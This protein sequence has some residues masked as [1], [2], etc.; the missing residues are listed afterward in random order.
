[1]NPI[2]SDLPARHTPAIDFAYLPG[3][4]SWYH[5]VFLGRNKKLD[6]RGLSPMA[7]DRDPERNGADLDE[8]FHEALELSRAERIALLDRIGAD[9]PEIR[10]ELESMLKIA[11]SAPE[12]MTPLDLGM[13]PA[14]LGRYEI[15][16][17]LGRGGMGIVFEARDTQLQRTVALKVLSRFLSA[18]ERGRERFIREARHLARLQHPNIAT[19]HSLEDC[20]G[21]DFLTMEYIDGSTLADILRERRLAVDEIVEL[22][23]QVATGLE[24]AHA[25]GICHCD[26]KPAN[27][28][29]TAS[30]RVSLLDFGIS[31][32]FGPD[33]L[34]GDLDLA[35]ATNPA[36]TVAGT[37]G[38]R[39]PEQAAGGSV[40]HRSDLWAFGIIVRECLTGR[41]WPDDAAAADWKA[42]LPDATSP[43]LV[44]IIRSCLEA[45]SEKRRITAAEIRDRLNRMA[46]R[47]GAGHRRAWRIG[48]AAILAT[49]AGLLWSSLKPPTGPIADLQ[50]VGG[51]TVRA[52]NGTDEI[53]WV[54]TFDEEVAGK[55]L[56]HSSRAAA[57]P[58]FQATFIALAP[59]AETGLISLLESR[60]GAERWRR[61]PEWL[62]PV[63]AIGPFVYRWL[64][65]CS[66]PGQAEP[67]LLAAVRDGIWYAMGIEAIS[68]DGDLLGVYHHPGPLS[69][70]PSIDENSSTVVMYGTNSSARFD[71]RLVPFETEHHP[72]CVVLL[73]AGR[74]DGQPFPYSRD[75]PEDRD[76][77]SLPPALERAYLLIPMLSP[78]SGARVDMFRWH[79]A[80]SESGGAHAA[81]EDGR[82]I[83]LDSDLRPLRALISLRTFADSLY[84]SGGVQNPPYL[85]IRDGR[86][87]WIDVPLSY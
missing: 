10:V 23:R 8:L 6:P 73:D 29:I 21:F 74:F 48:A 42:R 76:W 3:M 47:R 45:D 77:P 36:T 85:L 60:T 40:D 61:G 28:M 66:W 26:L 79:R 20:D 22:A 15:I 82:V 9:R 12:L 64:G 13:I 56:V 53:L 57:D 75:L 81:T 87:E 5:G 68:A 16:T 35:S 7:Y 39:S 46:R 51:H 67:V 52:V 80:G 65:A 49:A 54:R 70:D 44:E 38:Y 1:M 31:R 84:Q 25:Q 43:V 59:H 37:A 69:L 27:I 58:S 14:R 24:A 71:R 2:R 32:A 17:E 19:L 11:D 63:N 78:A 34:V 41:T 4:C 72:G 83:I 55:R 18:S 62:P 50:V 33:E 30:G 86:Q